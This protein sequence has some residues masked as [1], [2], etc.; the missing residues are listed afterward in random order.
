M[1]IDNVRNSA[2]D[3]IYRYCAL[4]FKAAHPRKDAPSPQL[5]WVAVGHQCVSELTMNDLLVFL[6]IGVFNR[7]EGGARAP[8]RILS[9]LVSS[10]VG[11]KP[12]K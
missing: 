7:P 5:R 4:Q 2:S 1:L 8:A 9:C 3:V 12:L 11:G 10:T 6:T